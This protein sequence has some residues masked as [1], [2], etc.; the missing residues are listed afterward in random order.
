MVNRKICVPLRPFMRRLFLFLS[1][2]SCLF[3]P[4]RLTAADAQSV[5]DVD[6]DST[7]RMSLLTCSPGTASYELYGHTALR[8]RS[9]KY[10]FDVVYN[11]GV[12]DFNQPHFVWHF[13]LGECDYMVAREDYPY[14]EFA[15]ARRGSSITEQVLNLYPAEARELL[16]ALEDNCQPDNCTYRYN[17][18]RKNCTTMARDMIEAHVFGNVRYPM[19]ARRLTYRQIL[20]QFTAGSPWDEAG[21][22][23]LLGAEVDTLLTERDEMFAPVYFMWYADSAMIERGYMRFD[24]LV[25]ERTIVLEANPELQQLSAAQE[26]SFPVSPAIVCWVLLVLGIL[27]ATWEIRARR[28]I[29][30]VDVVLMTLQG[31]AGIL[32]LFMIFFSTHPGVSSNWQ[33]WV[34]NPLPLLFLPAVVRADRRHEPCI[35]HMLSAA[36]LTLFLILS[37]FI[38]Q[39]FTPMIYPLALL[40]LSRAM[41]HLLLQR[42]TR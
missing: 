27:L 3:A 16:R 31:L 37:F 36:M 26:P 5:P 32:L 41:V 18:F 19:R 24:P 34:L 9:E 8:A 14:F 22:D 20:H 17:I 6:V 28:I 35:Y 7:L 15:Y 13:V 4:Q 30:G 12:F 23:L 2:L 29:W 42:I 38:P 40:L 1:F 11:Y 25:A 21:N 10:D 39:D 33:A